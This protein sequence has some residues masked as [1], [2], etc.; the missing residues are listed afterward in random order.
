M[1]DNPWLHRLAVLTASMTWLLLC[2]GALVTGTGSG[3]AV[4]D[5]P[6][7]YGQFF[8]PMVGG[9]LFEHG[10]RLVA[11]SVAI[12]MS[13]LCG[14]LWIAEP[15]SWVR[16]LGTAGL[17]AVLTQAVLGGLTVLFRLPTAVSVSH[18][19]L[20]QVFFS[21]TV[22][23]ALVTSASWHR[24]MVLSVEEEYRSWFPKLCLATTGM[25]LL[26]LAMG[27]VMRHTGSGL[28][29]PDFPTVFGHWWPESFSFPI[30]IHFAHRMGAY[31]SVILVS[32]L[33]VVV[34]SRYFTQ[35]HLTL[36]AGVLVSAV[37]FQV[38][39]GASI[40]WLKRPLLL[41]TLHLAVGAICLASSVSLTL[42]A[43]RLHGLGIQPA[44]WWENLRRADLNL[45]PR[46][47]ET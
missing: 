29:I 22:L 33:A 1:I 32:T 21:I 7:S 26:Q 16:W 28:A 18:A 4:P 8:P 25:L 45:G 15:R 41:T 20:A 37:L 36:F 2:A 19:C 30:A 44:I 5:W 12:L 38:M 6:L 9:V 31:L 13:L 40:L 10:H 24:P 27:A 35:F 34:V 47:V 46:G 23:L 17:F 43:F 39:L 3:L 42:I 11:G 14:F